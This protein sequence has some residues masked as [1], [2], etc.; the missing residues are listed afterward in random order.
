MKPTRIPKACRRAC[1]ETPI[2]NPHAPD[3]TNGAAISTDPAISQTAKQYAA[4]Q[5]VS[6]PGPWKYSGMAPIILDTLGRKLADLHWK[7]GASMKLQDAEREANGVL[8]A[9]A[10]ELYA[11]LWDLARYVD[12]DLSGHW[13]EH[14]VMQEARAA[15]AKATGR[16]A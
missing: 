8:M 10:P 1:C 4:M 16:Q 9:S 11:A 12:T 13:T 7:R 6:T 5:S 2:G 3:C 15:L 14:N